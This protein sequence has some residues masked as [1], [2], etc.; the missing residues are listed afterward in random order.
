MLAQPITF[1]CKGSEAQVDESGASPT[2]RAMGH[3]GSHANA[4]GQLAVAHAL[5]GEGFDAR[6]VGTGRG[7]PIVPVAVAF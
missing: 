5:R 2:L 3:A 7:T 4:G 6:E 1:D